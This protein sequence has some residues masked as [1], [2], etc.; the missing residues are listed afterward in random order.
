MPFCAADVASPATID[1]HEIPL[2]AFHVD[3]LM[4]EDYR[5]IAFHSSIPTKF[6]L[7]QFSYCFECLA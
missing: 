2:I 3:E 1:A 5:V 7:G 6:M 4:Q